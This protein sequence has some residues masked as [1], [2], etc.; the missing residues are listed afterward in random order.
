MRV[1]VSYLEDIQVDEKDAEAYRT[2]RNGPMSKS[3]FECLRCEQWVQDDSVKEII[4]G[5]NEEGE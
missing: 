3:L 4:D 2:A 1:Y 5:E